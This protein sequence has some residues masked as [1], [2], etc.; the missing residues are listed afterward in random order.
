MFRRTNKKVPVYQKPCDPVVSK[1]LLYLLPERDV[2]VKKKKSFDT[3]TFGKTTAGWVLMRNENGEEYF[4]TLDCPVCLC[5]VEDG[6]HFVLPCCK[7][8]LHVDCFMHQLRTGYES[9][10]AKKAKFDLTH[11]KC[12][13]CRSLY[14]EPE[15]SFRWSNGINAKVSGQDPRFWNEVW[16][17]VGDQYRDVKY[18]IEQQE[19]DLPE[20]EKGGWAIFNCE[21]C[22]K[23]YIPGKMSCAEEMNLNLEDQEFVCPECRWQV[24]AQDHR[25]FKHGKRYAIYKCDSCCSVARFDCF[26]NHYCQPCHDIP[27][28]RKFKPCPGEGK[29]PLGMPH[30]ANTEAILGKTNFGFVIGCYKCC[31]ESAEPDRYRENAPDPFLIGR[32]Q[33][34]GYASM[35]CYEARPEEEERLIA[36]QNGKPL[37]PSP[38]KP[39]AQPV[40]APEVKPPAELVPEPQE[41]E[42]IDED[43]DEIIDEDLDDITSSE[44]EDEEEKGLDEL[45]MDE[46]VVAVK[47]LPELFL[48]SIEV[49]SECEFWDFEVEDAKDVFEEVKRV[50]PIWVEPAAIVRL[51]LLK[52]CS[53]ELA[54][55]QPLFEVPQMRMSKSF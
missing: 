37:P 51:P 4:Y 25:C 16:K 30:P 3:N 43:L 6:G 24:K 22:D 48:G 14:T 15:R 28:K 1:V 44:S 27:S 29:C 21:S 50:S 54:E 41:P 36:I 39:P 2:L 17:P 26:H 38:P 55:K 45:L 34:K 42:I 52:T 8:L 49:D 23:L 9:T 11:L 18:L 40:P 7:N 5:D 31:D 12:P 47:D 10:Q 32:H 33:N 35:F 19:R 20:E 46:P 53:Q 13:Y